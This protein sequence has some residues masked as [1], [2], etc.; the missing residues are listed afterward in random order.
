MDVQEISQGNLELRTQV[1]T[2]DEIGNLA[3]SFN[4]MS[5]S[6]QQYIVELKDI[7]A[8]EERIA[9]E[10][11]V[12]TK[13]Q[14]DMLP[15][16]FPPFPD[17][18]EFDIYATMNPAK[19]VG[20]DFYDFFLIDDDHLGLVMADVSGKGVPAALFM[21]ISK[22]LLKNR[23]MLGESPKV[24]LENVNNQLCEN[25][26]QEMF[27]TVWFGIYEISTGK[28]TAANA[29]H[30]YPAICRRDGQFELYKDRHGLVLA[31]MENVKYREYELELHA[32][33]TLFVYTD[34][35]PEAT[36]AKE[37]LY[38]TD[39]MLEALNQNPGSGP[40]ELLPTVKADID[41]FVGDAPQFDDITMLALKISDK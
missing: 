5:A 14:A 34:G 4:S 36:N 39:R 22:T 15:Q 41:A 6:L 3:R 9:M 20:G 11:S 37:E 27:V 35:V 8:K 10:L 1:D 38:G 30:E 18:K 21:V 7:T 19:E 24:V 33:D 17:R 23:A 29:G 40:M 2:D 32:G 13:I 12:A 31:G 26:E 28:M 25:N 16:K